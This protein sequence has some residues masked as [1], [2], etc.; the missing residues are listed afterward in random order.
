M[1]N[2]HQQTGRNDGWRKN[3]AERC[4]R[5]TRSISSPRRCSKG[6]SRQGPGGGPRQVFQRAEGV[7]PPNAGGGRTGVPEGARHSCR[8]RQ[9]CDH[10]LL[11]YG[12]SLEKNTRRA[13]HEKHRVIQLQTK[14][15]SSSGIYL[16]CRRA[17]GVCS[18]LNCTTVYLS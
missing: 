10:R 4:L 13:N 1:N 7:C 9:V 16:L 11:W 5:Q 2:K 8:R 6:S 12:P 3:G 17:G 14:T 18:R 15:G